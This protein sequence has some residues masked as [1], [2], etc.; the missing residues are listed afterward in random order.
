MSLMSAPVPAHTSP[1][2]LLARLNPLTKIAM[3]FTIT[4]TALLVNSFPVLLSLLAI[5]VAALAISGVP[6]R[7]AGQRLLAI[8]GFSLSVV[9]L[10]TVASSRP[11][12][13]VI[14]LGWVQIT[15]AALSAG[16]IAGLRVAVILIPSALLMATI[17]PTDLADAL[18]QRLR[19]PHRFV[20][21]ALAA[22]RL[23]QTLTDDWRLLEQARRARGCAPD[24][25]IE[26]L[27]QFPSLIFALLVSSLRHG[28]RMAMAME[29][30]GLSSADRTWVRVSRFG[31]AD[32][33]VLVMVLLMCV[34]GVLA[35]RG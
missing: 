9:L 7:S 5:E 33:A 8:A 20:L 28:G 6:I 15:D 4:A 18:A 24:K 3:A 10:N 2:A 16:G 17:D 19:L 30:R 22:T 23:T 32:G 13:T 11:G 35:A 12:A 21:G 25:P 31:R 1:R 29:A 26:R 14:Q 27:R 34:S